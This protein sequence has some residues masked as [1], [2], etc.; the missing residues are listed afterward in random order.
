[1]PQTYNYQGQSVD[2]PFGVQLEG[3]GGN[4]MAALAA[5]E[6]RG[7][8]LGRTIAGP[9]SE[10]MAQRV[11]AYSR[12]NYGLD[13]IV[14]L[15]AVGSDSWVAGVG[16][17]DVVVEYLGH[18]TFGNRVLPP[19]FERIYLKPPVMP[20]GGPGIVGEQMFEQGVEAALLESVNLIQ[21]WFG[22]P[23]EGGVA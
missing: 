4:P 16:T 13:T 3:F 21:Q 20:D 1:V 2:H 22:R 9:L 5:I 6:Q 23:L 17:S 15:S 11:P 10:L 18:G 8:D 12:Y 7:A 19:D 14:P